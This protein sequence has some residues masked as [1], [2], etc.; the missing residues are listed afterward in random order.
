GG[1]VGGTGTFGGHTRVEAGAVLLRS[2][3]LRPVPAVF[4]DGA[5]EHAVVDGVPGADVG[6][7]DVVE[8]L[9]PARGCSGD[10]AL[11]MSFVTLPARFSLVGRRGGCVIG[12]ER[13]A[14]DVRGGG[15]HRRAAGRVLLIGGLGGG[16]GAG[17][18]AGPGPER[19]PPRGRA[20]GRADR[21]HIEI[22][23]SALGQQPVEVRRA[24]AVDIVD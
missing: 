12:V 17:L 21:A 19:Q 5:G 23:G 3:A 2:S 14:V 6:V 11:R 4:G 13:I 24:L 1:G 8:A 20:G 9:D 10:R 18:S 7:L 22:R 16:G 15:E